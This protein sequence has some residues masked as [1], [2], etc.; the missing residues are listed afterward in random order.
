MEAVILANGEFPIHDIPLDFLHNAEKI[1]CCDGAICKLLEYDE[2]PNIIIG[3]LDSVPEFV[4]QKY[5]SQLVYVTEQEN[6]DLTKAVNWCVENQISDIII[7]GA[8]GLRAD[9]TI[10]NIS[11]LARYGKL[12]NVTMIDNYGVFTPIYESTSFKSFEGQQVSIFSIEPET[13]ITLNSLMYPLNK[14]SLRE[15]WQG[16]LNE[17]LGDTFSIMFDK[18]TVVVFQSHKEPAE[19]I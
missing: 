9:H 12:A 6:N 4:K 5:A 18:G 14:F 3:D 11:L 7:L 17:S 2:E 1:I 15:W 16:T 13:P 8:T 19:R 10:G